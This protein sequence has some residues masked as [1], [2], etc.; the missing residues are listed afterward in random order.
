MKKLLVILLGLLSSVSAQTA[1]QP[2]PEIERL[3]GRNHVFRW[4]GVPGRVYFIQK[5]ILT[6]AGFVWEFA[7]DIRLGHGDPI[8]MGFEAD[9]G[10]VEFFRLVYIDYLGALDPDLAD[11]DHDGYTN[12]E[13]A[14]ENTDP[15]NAQSFPGSHEGASG[16][17]NGNPG[18]EKG[19]HGDGGESGGKESDPAWE[20]RLTY[21][22][23]GAN[24]YYHEEKL[25][26]AENP[27][28][29]YGYDIERSRKTQ[30]FFED[31]VGELSMR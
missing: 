19:G 15:F 25:I 3:E 12:L 2:L 22:Q 10:N 30:L 23:E 11:F 9:P 5:S 6:P 28:G 29:S 17:G 18:G 24:Y 7:P 31:L 1:P 20:Y 26:N 27:V 4:E 14:L 8:E 13:E 21:T 16:G